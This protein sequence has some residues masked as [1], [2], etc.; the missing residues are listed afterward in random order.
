MPPPSTPALPPGLSLLWESSDEQAALKAL[1]SL[2][3]DLAAGVR[4]R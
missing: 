2:T 1:A 3:E 4:S